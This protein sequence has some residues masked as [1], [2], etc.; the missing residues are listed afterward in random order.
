MTA[1]P[2]VA[3]VAQSQEAAMFSERLSILQNMLLDARRVN[4]GRLEA[5]IQRSI[6]QETKR[7]RGRQQES[8]AVARILQEDFDEEQRRDV[9]KAIE[10]QRAIEERR[11]RKKT[12]AALKE[13]EAKMQAQRKRLL[14]ASTLVE[15]RQ[16]LKRYELIDLGAG[17]PKGGSKTHVRNRMEV[18]ERIMRKG[19]PLPPDLANDWEW[20]KRK[21]DLHG[22]RRMRIPQAWAAKFVRIMHGLLDDIERGNGATVAR[23][24]R[25]E[26]RH[27]LTG[28]PALRV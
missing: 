23:W 19:D 24:M 21:Y 4:N 26:L 6:H 20:F 12:L 2:V 17:H 16:A 13:A 8:Q 27:A 10:E 15:C 1:E 22:A 5:A 9:L 11:E 18:M 14:E 28:A 25:I 7:A 3:E